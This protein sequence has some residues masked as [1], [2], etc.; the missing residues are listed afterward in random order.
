M[1]Y[2]IQLLKNEENHIWKH[3]PWS[4]I[5]VKHIWTLTTGLSAHEPWQLV[6]PMSM[7]TGTLIISG[8]GWWASAFPCQSQSARLSVSINNY[9]KC[10]WVKLTNRNTEWLKGLKINEIRLNT[11]CERLNLDWMTHIADK[12]MDGEYIQVNAKQKNV[13]VAILL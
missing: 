2:N 13:G 8:L 3:W 7:L 1:F 9:C 12:W 5:K 10:E 11:V 6:H 4:S